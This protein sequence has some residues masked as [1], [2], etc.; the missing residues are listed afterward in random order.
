MNEERTN[1]MSESEPSGTS[2]LRSMKSAVLVP[3][4]L[5]TAAGHAHLGPGQES[6]RS[7]EAVLDSEVAN[8]LQIECVYYFIN[9]PS[10]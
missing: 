7:E 9:D 2:L 4:E 10:G 6:A 3:C 1:I 5:S 8:T